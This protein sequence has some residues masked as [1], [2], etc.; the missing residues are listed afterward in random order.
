MNQ[1]EHSSILLGSSEG[2]LVHVI[3]SWIKGDHE[4][5]NASFGDLCPPVV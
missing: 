3:S 2:D 1:F 4:I 5:V